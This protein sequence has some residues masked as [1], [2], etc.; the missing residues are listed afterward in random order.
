M[1]TPTTIPVN[2]EAL[3]AVL[4]ALNGPGHLIRELQAIR[5]IEPLTG[6]INPINELIRNYNEAIQS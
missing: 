6:R 2:A 3:R 1:S 4:E 5:G